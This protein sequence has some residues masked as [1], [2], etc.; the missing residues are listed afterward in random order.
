MTAGSNRIDVWQISLQD[1]LRRLSAL[2]ALLSPEERERMERFRYPE[3]AA[4]FATGRGL[5]RNIL[6]EYTDT[7][8]EKLQL[9]TGVHQKPFLPFSGAP[10]FN[11]SHTDD[12]LLIAV[13]SSAVG[14]DIEKIRP[15]IHLAIARRFFSPAENALLEQL[16]V[17]EKISVFFRLWT[18]REAI[19]KMT[20]EGFWSSARFTLD[21]T[22][23]AQ[24]LLLPGGRT[25]HLQYL[26]APP[27]HLIALAASHP[28]TNVYFMNTLG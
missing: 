22:T 3:H 8:A 21:T 11:L 23:P 7:P 5:L 24:A 26:D 28:V 1:H 2:T 14:I 15:D 19:L 25:C 9:R 4:R 17:S 27:G 18:G 13:A 6:S 12:H 20:G 10:H 16:P